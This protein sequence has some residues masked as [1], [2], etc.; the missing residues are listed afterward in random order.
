MSSGISRDINAGPQVVGAAADSN[1]VSDKIRRLGLSPR[2]LE[3]N[4]LYSYFRTAQHDDCAT[5]WDG[6]QN[7]DNVTRASIV[8]SAALP[9]GY[10]DTFGELEAL[11]MRY[12]RP[13]VPCHLCHLVISRFTGLLF[14][15]QTSPTWKVPGDPDTEGW[16]QAVT[17]AYGL[18]SAM[19]LARNMGGAMGTAV[20]GFKLIGG[21]VVFESIDRRWCFPTFDPTNPSELI[22]LEIRYMYP[23]EVRDADTG[24]WKEENYWYLRIIDTTTD[25]VWKPQPVG[26]GSS[27]PKWDDPETVEEMREH[28]FGEVPYRWIPN[29]EV[30]D[31]LDGDPD[32]L[33]AYDYF[34]RIG[35]LDSAIHGGAFR[36]ADPTPVISSDASL[37]KV[38]MGSKSAIKLEKG[39]TLVFAETSGAATEAAAKESDRLEDKALQ[40]CECVL[41]DQRSTDGAPMTAT[42]ITKRTSSMFAKASMLRTQ[43]GQRGVVLL[44]EM[45]LRVAHKLDRGRPAVPGETDE[46]GN[47][48]LPGTNVRESIF[49]PPKV[50]GDKLVEHKLANVK[51]AQLK[52]V[53]PPFSRPT[54]QETGQKVTATVQARAGRL[55]TL[56]T[57][58]RNLAADFSIENPQK[59]VE[60]LKKEPAPEDDLAAKSLT[61]LN[62]GR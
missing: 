21:K 17:D 7:A 49:V 50:Q 55:I 3:L 22:K 47:P 30:L 9:P 8:S 37:T 29:I 59:E 39:G 62:E 26:D 13:S 11:P 35:E 54:P 48:I 53:W 38:G 58:V 23:K 43:Y 5:N 10:Q 2:Q 20:V 56:D 60:E 1:L 19:L 61:E 12:R 16:V 18:W 36:N 25:C 31:D 51:G 24:Q 46:G 15:E 52:L 32:C 44:M 42:E 27:E 4:R 40:I 6:S 14:G 33:G 45:L 41:A 34:D 57:G 28:N